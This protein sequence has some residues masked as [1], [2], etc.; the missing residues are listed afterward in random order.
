MPHWLITGTDTG[1]GKTLLTAALAVY[2]QR[3]RKSP[4][5][6]LK[7]VQCGPGDREYF[8]DLFAGTAPT[9]TVENPV[10]FE[11]PI[12]PPLAAA[13]EGG[14]VDLAAVWQSYQQARATHPLVLVEG[15]GGLGCPLTWE[16]TV[17]DLAHDWRIPT[18]LVAPIRLGVLGQLVVH[19]GF[20]R[21]QKIDLRGIV[22]STVT[23]LDAEEQAALADIALIEN[24]C[25][26]PVLG[27]LPYLSDPTDRQALLSA[28]AGLELSRLAMAA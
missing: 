18:L 24:L 26:L 9:V 14:A 12:A 20:A 13:R 21:S 1:V 3:Y 11:A 8:Q 25:G 28:C 4:L 6:I 5:A 16:Y 27:T 10:Y 22:L 15:V 2:W 23:P 17:A 7:P 19:V